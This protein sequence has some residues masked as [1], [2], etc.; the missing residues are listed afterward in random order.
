MGNN[1]VETLIGAVVL[2]IAVFF[3]IFAY[4]A[5]EVRPSTGYELSARFTRVDGLSVGSDVRMSGIKVGTVVEQSL[6]R[7]TFDALVVFNLSDDVKIPD[8][9]A[10]KI[11]SDGLLGDSY[12]SLEPGGSDT[13][14]AAGEE[15]TITQ[16]AVNLM[17]LIAQ[18]VFGSAKS[19]E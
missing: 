2:I 16:G 13:F 19:N 18:A 8:D 10:V 3:V 15:L 14:L 17:D 1:I 12:V 7:E 11:T 4:T 9:T 6:D 5:T